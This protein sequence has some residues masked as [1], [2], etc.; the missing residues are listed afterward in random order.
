M[1][2]VYQTSRALGNLIIVMF[3]GKDPFKRLQLLMSFVAL[4]GWSFLS[5]FDRPSGI[6]LFSFSPYLSET[7]G[8]GTGSIMPLF[9]LFCVGLNESIVILQR[10]TMLETAS[11]SPS[12]M[13]DESVV[14]QRF[15]F[16]YGFVSFGATVAF[17]VGGWLYSYIGYYA[18]CD[19]GMI[20]QF[21]HLIG[22][23]VYLCLAVYSK[24]SLQVDDE[25]DGNDLIRSTIYQ[26]Q[27]VSVIS[28][29]SQD[30]A[31]GAENAMSLDLQGLSDAVIK[32]KSDRV[33]N[34]SLG[35][36]Y[37]RFFRQGRDDV[38]CMEEL[39]SSICDTCA[40]ASLVSNRPLAQSI[41][42]QK[43]SK[44]VIFLMKSRGEGR[45]SE[46]EFVSFWAPRIYLSIYD[47]SQ[48]TSVNVIWPYMRLVVATQAVAALCIGKSVLIIIL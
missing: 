10:S 2:G 21:L 43:L 45:I 13:I 46:R 15:S 34:H 42:K 19:F 6:S 31:N 18:V 33:L 12:G 14:A 41:N 20:V 48:D 25:L 8:G 36:L 39:I 35:E 40:K 30:V 47:A 26:F 38:T 11:E 4:F 28:K 7:D 44:L 22:A 5:L 16:Q 32:A 17:I 23:A 9:A 24:K 1:L 37:R 29:Y 27:A 3:G